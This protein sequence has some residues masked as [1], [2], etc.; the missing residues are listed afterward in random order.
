MLMGF[1]ASSHRPTCGV[2]VTNS[3]F[4]FFPQASF[5]L[6]RFAHSPSYQNQKDECDYYDGQRQDEKISRIRGVTIHHPESIAGD[7]PG[8]QAD[9]E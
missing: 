1:M 4:S 3:W 7:K 2:R 9:Y 6:Q 5:L 8:D